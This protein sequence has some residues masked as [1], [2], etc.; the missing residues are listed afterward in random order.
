MDIK[1]RDKTLKKLTRCLLVLFLLISFQATVSAEQMDLGELKDSRYRN[2]YFGF[3]I[4]IPTKWN[5][6]SKN[7]I[8][9]VYE[10]AKDIVSKND[11]NI[12]T[13]MEGNNKPIYLLWL[14]K[15]PIGT[16]DLNPNLSIVELDLS[17]TVGITRGKQLFG[18]ITNL[19]AN[20]GLT[21]EMTKESE[22][23]IDGINFDTIE[24]QAN[25]GEKITKTKCSI[26]ILR[27]HALILNYAY[28]SENESQELNS[29]IQSLNFD[30]WFLIDKDQYM[31]VYLDTSSVVVSG[32]YISCWIMIDAWN[33]IIS[34]HMLIKNTG[35]FR[36]MEST[37]PNQSG[38]EHT[39]VWDEHWESEDSN[40]IMGRRIKKCVQWIEDHNLSQN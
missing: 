25:I 32:E 24:L 34:H 39:T 40:L 38:Q 12:K 36:T 35:A 26:A 2:N 27:G 9:Q 23:T 4:Q 30:R 1:D 22:E 14:S 3:T 5:V 13:V 11:D 7:R 31:R 33:F 29:I 17:G 18:S 10:K 15:Y 20:T 8:E 28:S 37:W 16:T 19:F 6:I 21:Y